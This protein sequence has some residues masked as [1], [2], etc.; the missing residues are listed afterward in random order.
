LPES[1]TFVS[2][3]NRVFAD[4]G[5]GSQAW[6]GWPNHLALVR[7]TPRAEVNYQHSPCGHDVGSSFSTDVHFD[8]NEFQKIEKK[9]MF[10]EG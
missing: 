3:T 1:K 2:K 4:C 10:V 6:A 7:A 9:S 8:N 5:N